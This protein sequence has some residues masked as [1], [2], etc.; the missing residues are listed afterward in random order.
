MIIFLFHSPIPIVQEQGWSIISVYTIKRF[1]EEKTLSLAIKEKE[2]QRFWNQ[3]HN[4]SS[5]T[6]YFPALYFD[7]FFV[8]FYFHFCVTINLTSPYL[9]S[10][11]LTEPHLTI[12]HHTSPD[13]TSPHLTSP[14]L[15]S[16]H[17]T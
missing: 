4:L 11:Y 7:Y 5:Y 17:L 3:V 6:D 1:S 8:S 13:L 16:P 12:P 10:P 14:H 2:E 9:T 15:T